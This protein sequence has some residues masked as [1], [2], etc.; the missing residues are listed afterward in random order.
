MRMGLK[1]FLS[2]SIFAGMLFFCT[3]SFVL[4]Y[5]S[6]QDG[7]SENFEGKMAGMGETISALSSLDELKEI[8]KLDSE[9]AKTSPLYLKYHTPLSRTLQ[10]AGA[11]F[12]YLFMYGGGK[13]L[14]YIVDAS[15]FN[16]EDWCAPNFEEDSV[17]DDLK[18]GLMHAFRGS[19]GATD[20][21]DTEEW[22]LMRSGTYPID[23][24]QLRS[25]YM[26]GVDVNLGEIASRT[27]STM[28]QAVFVFVIISAVSVF[29][30]SA[31][32]GLVS[33]SL[34]RVKGEIL[35]I[36]AGENL[37]FS[38][39]ESY[40]E[41]GE[42]ARII[43]SYSD[44]VKKKIG[45]ARSGEGKISRTALS[46]RLEEALKNRAG[47]FEFFIFNPEN[48]KKFC[49]VLQLGGKFYAWTFEKLDSEIVNI[50]KSAGMSAL[51]ERSKLSREELKILC[52][53]FTEFSASSETVFSF[54]EKIHFEI[55]KSENGLEAEF[56]FPCG[57]SAKGVE[58]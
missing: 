37:D 57:A 21:V 44:G 3:L 27:A 40:G 17:D 33:K 30:A 23:S 51:L 34:G 6:A 16:S 8:L 5:K 50:A 7:I 15:A 35:K 28:T 4:I 49:G 41:L 29:A 58:R 25:F 26:T 13:D 55:R 12:I 36:G 38:A 10:E 56:K 54:G 1:T 48:S 39:L 42:I 32:A 18:A 52:C 11:E 2:M 22:G 24:G 45:R 20:I 47:M 9:S 19:G 53:D 43:F 31:F 14:L 46:G